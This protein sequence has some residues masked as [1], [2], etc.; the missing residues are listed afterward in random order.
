MWRRGPEGGESHFHLACFLS[1]GGRS[2][3][4]LGQL[5]EAAALDESLAARARTDTDLAPLKE[6]DAFRELTG[7]SE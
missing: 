4:A 7:I 6:L 2:E 1:R 5:R 3:E